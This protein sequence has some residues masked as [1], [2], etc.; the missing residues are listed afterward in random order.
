MEYYIGLMSGT[1]LDGCD[2]ALVA[3]EKNK[4]ELLGF[5]S[6]PMSEKL[7]KQIMDCCSLDKSNIALACSLNFSLGHYLADTAK[8]LCES[9]DFDIKKVSAIASHGQTVYHIPFKEGEFV[10]STLQLGEPAVIAYETGVPVVSSMRAMDMAAGGQGAPLVPFAEYI[11]Y[12]G[13]EDIALQNLGGIGNVT[14]IPANALKSDVFAFDTGPANMIIDSLV[15]RFFGKP[16]DKDGEIAKSGKLVDAMLSEWMQIP[17]VDMKPPKSTGREL[18]GEQFV[19]EQIKLHKDVAPEDFVATATMYTAKTMF[20]NYELFV[21]PRCPG[22][23][24]IVLSGGGAHNKAMRNMMQGLFTNCNIITQE[25]LG[26]SSDAKEA[27]AFAIIGRETMNRRSGNLPSV[28]GA[29]IPVPLGSI[30]YPPEN[31]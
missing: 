26:F 17:Y 4:I 16:Y 12:R 1:S 31:L 8:M 24:K 10:P 13:K 22:L 5:V 2:A 15:R 14:V 19:D 29:K 3:F 18:Y 9:L 30:V 25:D 21:F 20:R 7:R 23:K 28:T 27:V 6:N 11:L